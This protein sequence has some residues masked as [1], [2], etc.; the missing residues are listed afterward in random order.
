MKYLRHILLSAF[1]VLFAFNGLSQITLCPDMSSECIDAPPGSSWYWWDGDGDGIGGPTGACKLNPGSGWVQTCGDCNDSN[2]NIGGPS[3]W[4]AD[5]DGDGYGAGIPTSD[6]SSPGSNWV[7]NN[8]DCNDNDPNIHGPTTWYADNDGDGFGNPFSTITSCTQ[9]NGYVSNND[10]CNDNDPSTTF[11]TFYRDSD[12]DNFGDP[13]VSQ[14]GCILPAG[15]VTNDDDCDDTNSFINP[16]T[17]WY[18]DNDGDGY[19]DHNQTSIQQCE[20]P[21]GYAWGAHDCDDNNEELHPQTIWYVDADGDGFGDDPTNFIVQCEDPGAGYSLILSPVDPIEEDPLPTYPGLEINDLNFLQVIEPYNAV[22]TIAAL[23]ALAEDQKTQVKTFYDGLGRPM[24]EIAMNRGGYNQDVINYIEYDRFGRNPKKYMPYGIANATSGDFKQNAKS[25]TE[26]FYANG[27]IANSYVSAADPFSE[28]VF[29]RSPR[30][31][32]TRTGSAGDSWKIG[33][34]NEVE[35]DYQFNTANSVRMFSVALTPGFSPTLIDNS[36]YYP[37]NVLSVTTIKDEN[38]TSGNNNTTREYKNKDG[39]VI[40]K[41][42]YIDGDQL[43]TYYV[44]DEYSNLTYIIPPKADPDA[45]VITPTLLNSLCYQFKFDGLR[46]QVAKRGPDVTGWEQVIYDTEDRPVLARDPNLLAEGKWLFT[47]YDKFGRVLYTGFYTPPT[48]KSK[49]EPDYQIMLNNSKMLTGIHNEQRGVST[50]DGVTIGYTNDAFPNVGLEVISVTYYD[51]YA[52]LDPD[53]P[54]TPASILG[55]S[56]TTNAKGFTVAAWNRTLGQN[57]W[58]KTYSYYDLKGRPL[59]SY[60]KNHLSGYNKIDSEYDFRGK[61]LK[62]VTRHKRVSSDSEITITNRFTFDQ[63]ERIRTKSQKIN[64]EP[65]KILSGFVYD[66]IG[67]LLVKYIEPEDDNFGYQSSIS[68]GGKGSVN[69]QLINIDALQKI[70]YKYNTRGSLKEINN[71]NSFTEAN[72]SHDV[73]AYKINYDEVEGFGTSNT[74]INFNGN[75]TQVLW[76]TANDNLKRNY[77]YEYDPLSQI[78]KATFSSQAYNLQNVD[79]DDNGNILALYRNTDTG[80]QSFN[81]HYNS[82]NQLTS[83]S[84]TKGVGSS[85][86]PINKTFTYDGN[87]NLKSDSDKGILNIDYNYLNLPEEI[88][89]QS[90]EIIKYDYDAAGR[91]LKKQFING[92]SNT[93]TEYIGTFQYVNTNLEF[94]FQAEGYVVPDGSGSYDYVYG[95]SD[96]LGNIRLSYH[97]SNG[98]GKVSPD[99][100]VKESNYY[101]FGLTHNYNT[102]VSSL[103]SMFHYSFAGKELQKENEIEWYD[104]G[105]RNYDPELGRWFNRDPQGQFNSPYL[106]AFNNPISS[107]DPDGEFAFTAVLAGA[108]IGALTG[109]T[110]YA[111]AAYQSGTWEW[112]AFAA[113]VGGGA[114][115]GAISGGFASGGASAILTGDAIANSLFSG[116]FSTFTPG[117]NVPLGDDL[118]VGLSPALAFGTTGVGLGA[119]ATATAS[120]GDFD[121]S[122]GVGYTAHGKAVGTGKSGSEFRF[123][124]GVGYDDGNFSLRIYSTMFHD[125]NDQETNQQVGGLAIGLNG[126]SLR[127]ENDGTPFQYLGAGDGNDSFRTAALQIAYKDFGAGFNL[128]TG[129]RTE[130]DTDDQV[131]NK[132]LPGPYGETYPHGHVIERGTPYRLGAAYVSYKGARFGIDSDRHVRHPIQNHMAHNFFQ[133]QPGFHVYSDTVKIYQQFQTYNPFTLW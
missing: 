81:Y 116:I 90:G 18:P 70:D 113:A 100:I 40:L 60:N 101:P 92:S 54:A 69:Y 121:I 47:K 44:Y 59:Q 30:N 120:I 89:F 125:S 83:V 24:Q 33:S 52:F 19:G 111:I 112:G 84:G 61:A 79:Y 38:W 37:A 85:I 55:Q 26:S 82:G 8:D 67:Q 130:F 98:N 103:G 3:F 93:T 53:K 17:H 71:V 13:N 29:D 97:D 133:P 118:T 57:T 75:I 35:F 23:D 16:N 32:T 131:I 6:C 28:T 11:L 80:Y 42:S 20:Q 41:R 58:N 49:G 115:T 94:L 109:A 56:V 39:Q 36:E 87:G 1:L 34:G 119:N 10:D 127:Y 99:E 12:N 48:S 63:A 46:R 102:G 122:Y 132:P 106:Y 68:K 7:S 5:N 114:I 124:G 51:D 126:I 2:S 64:T 123:S 108:L 104:F 117:V 50:I 129:K 91:K 128:F 76:K 77:Q 65:E 62:T 105:S 74:P 25:E 31:R 107:V 110:A 45:N 22:S 9:P 72:G 27:N 78:K 14:E 95:Y 4:Y 15:Y 88:T 96:H 43:S 86:I 73:F 21:I 66:A